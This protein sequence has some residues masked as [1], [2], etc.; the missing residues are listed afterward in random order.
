MTKQPI[1]PVRARDHVQ[2]D[3]SALVTLIEYGD[4]QC[5]YCGLAY[6]IVKALQAKFGAKLRFAFRNFPLTDI[7]PLAMGAA[8]VAEA[9]ALQGKFWEMHDWL[10]ENQDALDPKSM[11]DEAARLHLDR[12]QMKEAILSHAAASHVQEDFNGALKS[13]LTGTPAFFINGRQFSGDWRELA[14]FSAAIETARG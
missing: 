3:A 8:E 14:E 10:Y 6:P 12:G 11:M 7:H 4:Y 5:S 9:A 2:G 1:P 13:G